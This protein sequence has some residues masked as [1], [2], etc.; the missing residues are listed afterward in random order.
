MLRFY[1]QNVLW[2]AFISL[3]QCMMRRL[4]AL[5][6]KLMRGLTLILHRP[7]FTLTL[8]G[9]SSLI[10]TAVAFGQG[11]PG[12]PNPAPAANP[13]PGNPSTLDAAG[14]QSNSASLPPPA[15]L[16]ANAVD[17]LAPLPPP[18][19]APA[20]AAAPP[21]AN[22]PQA[23]PFAPPVTLPGAPAPEA[24]ATGISTAPEPA[25]PAIPDAALP[26]LDVPPVVV[27]DAPAVLPNIV[28]PAKEIS[29]GENPPLVSTASGGPLL[30]PMPSD[31]TLASQRLPLPQLTPTSPL[32]PGPSLAE[33][34][35]QR[36]QLTTLPGSG[37]NTNAAYAT[38]GGPGGPARPLITPPTILEPKVGHD[39]AKNYPP[40][41][42]VMPQ[43]GATP[44]HLDSPSAFGTPS[45][46]YTLTYYQSKTLR[47]NPDKLEMNPSP[48]NT[49][50]IVLRG[51]QEFQ[52]LILEKGD[53]WRVELLNGTIIQIPGA[54][55]ASVRKL[56][57]V[58]TSTPS[59]RNMV[60]QPQALYRERQTD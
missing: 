43:P 18:P 53:I 26:P 35:N 59:A 49:E 10:W 56:L 1:W 17:S 52:G 6:A 24:F 7:T 25:L 46:A 29:P 16:S 55:V 19:P 42:A 48:T 44:F 39:I 21:P 54:K 11:L 41:Q 37:G 12:T 57:A 13:A 14:A 45:P 2:F 32:I 33:T 15:P 9:C 31:Q 23:N 38:I 47:Q 50:V 22:A 20:P 51:G 34:N 60:F 27:P 3:T 40:L 5:F 58:P 30:P 8:L 4:F 36:R 28:E